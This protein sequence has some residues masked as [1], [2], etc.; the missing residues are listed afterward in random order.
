VVDVVRIGLNNAGWAVALALAAAVVARLWRQ[1]P[2][3]AHG[4]WLLVLLKLVTP[5]LVSV[6]LPGLEPTRVEDSLNERDPGSL[7]AIVS[8]TPGPGI[9]QVPGTAES[10]EPG[11]AIT[12]ADEPLI[13][14]GTSEGLEPRRAKAWTWQPFLVVLWLAGAGA[15]WLALAVQTSRFGRIVCAASPASE[16]LRQQSRRIAERLGLRRFP[17]IL[18][19]PARMPPMLWAI[20]GRP[21]VLLPEALWQKFDDAQR[22][23]V[24]AH[25]LAHLR[26]GD[27][28]VR[29]L[30][31]AVLGLY[32]W[33]P[34]AWWARREVER[35]EEQCCDS[36]VT[37]ALPGSAPAYAE[38][39]VATADF[40][41]GSC[42]R[43]PWPLGASGVGRVP[44]LK[45]RLSMI[46]RTP[47][48]RPAPRALL[49]LAAM[50]LPFLPSWASGQAPTETPKQDPAPVPTQKPAPS[51]P[52]TKPYADLPKAENGPDDPRVKVAQP[53]VREVRDYADFLGRIEAV[54]SAEIRARVSGAIEAV[55]FVPGAPVKQGD[56]LFKIDSRQYQA[57]H[58]RAQAT[59]QRA[60]ARRRQALSVVARNDRML[61][62]DPLIVPKEDQ[63]RAR[64]QVAEAAAEV[65]L[66]KPSVDLASL[67]LD[68]TNVRAPF[69]GKVVNI[70]VNPGEVVAADTRTLATVVSVDP[71]C[72]AFDVDE[73]TI[74]RLNRAHRE[75]EIKQGPASRMRVEVRLLAE[76]GDRTLVGEV[77]PVALQ[78]NPATGA[79]PFRAIL[80]N[81]DRDLLPGMSASVRLLPGPPREAVLVPFHAVN[82]STREIKVVHENGRLELRRINIGA[83]YGNLFAVE[84]VKPSEWFVVNIGDARASI[85]YGDQTK[86]GRLSLMPIT[87]ERVTLPFA[88]D[89]KGATDPT[90][91]KAK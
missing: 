77:A 10:F 19:V 20:F 24:L 17:E 6:S 22:D 60:E 63:E 86:D 52:A 57:E 55:E 30:E 85:Y 7:S 76:E 16:A 31:A 64:D 28:W 68:F 34:I 14:P 71:V 56:L 87:P 47:M 51:V 73:R 61:K 53:I 21:R 75:G 12:R 29:R 78:I 44:L 89:P 32:W 1:R 43:S 62:R 41:S 45:G 11:P 50:T 18:L 58:D 54:K 2:A 79:A 26:R 35:A 4:L 67:N 66:A 38:A 25:E 39:L 88:A 36:W 59:M 70:L 69:D 46:L 90:P 33:N 83:T 37:W 27:H 82:Q 15:W 72:V 84:G 5:G 8:E 3:L 74:I 49:V 80:A 23:S 40:L 65:A 91:S 9:D 48:T 81:K 13:T 42:P